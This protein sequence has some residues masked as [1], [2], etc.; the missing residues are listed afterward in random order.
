MQL[1]RARWDLP[2]TGVMAS[3][4]AFLVDLTNDEARAAAEP[5]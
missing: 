4:G 3:S 1:E 5:M 2:I